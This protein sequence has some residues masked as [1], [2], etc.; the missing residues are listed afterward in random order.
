VFLV[1]TAAC[2]W[3]AYVALTLLPQVLGPRHQAAVAP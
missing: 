1:A 3:L 2:A